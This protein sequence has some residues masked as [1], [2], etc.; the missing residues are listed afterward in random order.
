MGKKL[1][2]ICSFFLIFVLL[3]GLCSHV[4]LPKTN[5][6]EAGIHDP[7]AKGFLA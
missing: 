7:W 3:F 6:K 5:S 1:L 4:L 2:R